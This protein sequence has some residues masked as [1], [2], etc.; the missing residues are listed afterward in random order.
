MLNEPADFQMCRVLFQAIKA[1]VVYILTSASIKD[2]RSFS[3]RKAY[4]LRVL[5]VTKPCRDKNECMV[6]VCLCVTGGVRV[7]VCFCK[8][9]KNICFLS[10]YKLLE[11]F[12][13]LMKHPRQT[14]VAYLFTIYSNSFVQYNT[15]FAYNIQTTFNGSSIQLLNAFECAS[16]SASKPLEK[17]NKTKHSNH[18]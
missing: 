10:L 14:M 4:W 2:N 11:T 13:A 18:L 7:C 5:T 17:L 9:K 15:V 6:G 8:K 12:R 16:L 3:L 1:L